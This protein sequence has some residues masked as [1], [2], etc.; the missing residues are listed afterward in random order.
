MSVV[1]EHPSVFSDASKKSKSSIPEGFR[2]DLN[3]YR[4]SLMQKSLEQVI[5][6]YTSALSWADKKSVVRDVLK[7]KV[8]EKYGTK[9]VFIEN[10][11]FIMKIMCQ[12]LKPNYDELC[13]YL[14]ENKNRRYGLGE[15]HLQDEKAL[16]INQFKAATEQ[17]RRFYKKI[18]VDIFAVEKEEK[19]IAPPYAGDSGGIV[20]YSK[21]A[22]KKPSYNPHYAMHRWDVPFRQVIVG[23]CCGGKVFSISSPFPRYSLFFFRRPTRCSTNLTTSIPLSR[24]QRSRKF[25]SSPLQPSSLCTSFL[26]RN[27]RW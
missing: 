26:G 6:C 23:P 15:K 9:E 10:Q 2:G 7:F 5:V 12:C 16:V 3:D 21:M 13:V 20:D 25:T 14:Q 8:V 27:V 4:S 22:N 17:A 18:L 1:S 24:R 11:S 19:P